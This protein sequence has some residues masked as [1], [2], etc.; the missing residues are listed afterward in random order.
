MRT[1]LVVSLLVIVLC[2]VVGCVRGEDP[3]DTDSTST[4]TVPVSSVI[5]TSTTET[6]TTTT[7]T[8]TNSTSTTS[9]ELEGEWFSMAPAAGARL[10]VIGVAHDD[11]LNV[12]ELPGSDQA[13]IARFD[14]ITDGIVATG[15][16]WRLSSSIWFEV[17]LPNG[18]PGWVHSSYVAQAGIVDDITSRVVS[19]LEGYPSA[20][21]MEELGRL[22]A[23][24]QASQDPDSRIVMVQAPSG[25]DVG[26]VIFD[27][28][29]LGDD[30]IRALRLWVFGSS[31]SGGYSL[32][33][34]EAQTMCDA[35]RGESGGM[36]N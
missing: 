14:P 10:A 32:K 27:V 31:G 26:E 3:M 18:E 11:V 6:T 28:V 36:C 9:R 12:R 5:T 23:E 7:T 21:S 19:A 33:S 30:S 1:R 22:V 8:V 35:V 2:F 24:S 17:Q 25:T 16:A 13:I 29:G 20:T 15:Q 4:T 34:V